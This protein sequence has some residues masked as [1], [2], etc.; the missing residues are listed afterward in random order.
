M[1]QHTTPE[2]PRRKEAK[3]EPCHRSNTKFHKGQ[4]PHSAT[5]G[6]PTLRRAM[7]HMPLWP[8]GEMCHSL[9]RKTQVFL[10]GSQ[11]PRLSSLL[12]RLQRL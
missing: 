11:I 4:T 6:S 2:A 5:R 10:R 3:R 12:P 7:P 9:L 1:R 8:S